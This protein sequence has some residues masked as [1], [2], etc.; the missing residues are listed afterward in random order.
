MRIVKKFLSLTQI[1]DLSH[2]SHFYTVV[3]IVQK[4][5]EATNL[6]SAQKLRQKSELVYIYKFNPHPDFKFIAS[7][8]L[9]YG[10]HLDRN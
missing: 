8:S 7:L 10:T 5:E 2:P 9:L 4:C 3:S 6:K 1:L